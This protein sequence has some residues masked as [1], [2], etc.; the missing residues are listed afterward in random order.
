L[1]ATVLAGVCGAAV[2]AVNAA[3]SR[4]IRS[5]SRT[6]LVIGNSAYRNAPLENPVNDARLVSQTLTEL[7]FVVQTVE[8]ATLNAMLDSMGQWISDSADAKVR[9]FY[10]AGHGTQFRGDNYLVPVDL[11]LAQ[12]SEIRRKAVSLSAFV[13]S[14]SAQREAVNFVIVDACRTDPIALLDGPRE[15]SRGIKN[16]MQ[17]G[18]SAR[19]APRGTVVAYSTSP[20]ALAA[21][22]QGHGNSIFTQALTEYLRSPGLTVERM[23]KQVRA[24]VMRATRNSQVPWESSSLVGDFCFQPNSSGQCG[25]D[26]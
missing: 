8:N 19:I 9:A 11:K 24:R 25:I 15:L 20:G 4:S 5:A 23:F 17:P 1:F 3:S 21:D 16:L 10:F 18:F 2:P 13:D 7:G 22:S 6:A 12:E 26:E 14:L